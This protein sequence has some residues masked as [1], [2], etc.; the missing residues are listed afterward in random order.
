MS[1]GIKFNITFGE[2]TIN[3]RRIRCYF[4]GLTP[5]NATVTLSKLSGV[6]QDYSYTPYLRQ[7]EDLRGDRNMRAT[8][9]TERPISVRMVCMINKAVPV[10]KIHEYLTL[11]INDDAPEIELTIHKFGHFRGKAR[12]EETEL[13]DGIQVKTIAPGS[14]TGTECPEDLIW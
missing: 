12:I 13:P 9:F 14:N 11:N 5:T 3:D 7:K 4:F 2:K 1:K 6:S 10:T 8:Y